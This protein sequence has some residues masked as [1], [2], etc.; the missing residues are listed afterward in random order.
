MTKVSVVVPVYNASKYLR[1]TLDSL[2]NQSLE[3]MEIIA[4]DDVS[5]DNSLDILKEYEKAYPNKIRVLVNSKNLGQGAT[6][7]KGIKLAKGKYI[8]FVDSDDYVSFDM[9]K[10]M[11]ENASLN[12]FPEVVTM[13]LIFVKDNYYFD[14]KFKDLP[15]RKG[16]IVSLEEDPSFILNQSPSTCNKLF[17]SDTIKSALFLENVMWEDVA[18]TYAKMFN[19]KHILNINTPGYFY[20]RTLNG[21]SG[22]GYNI[23]PNILDIIKVADQLEKEVKASK[24]YDQFKHQIEYIQITSC[25]QRVVEIMSWPIPTT[26]I[27]Q[28]CMLMCQI[29]ISKYGDWKR[30]SIEELS[31]KVGYLELERINNL[32]E[33]A[34]IS[35]ISDVS[36]LEE[37]VNSFLI[38]R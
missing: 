21:V 15:K 9:Y 27:N 10:T 24:R 17:R 1:T 22:K 4:I 37:Q 34:V 28:L 16:T 36:Y 38:N 13:G 7:N 26:E 5:T 6:R 31:I 20:R 30:F 3:D 12:D 19:A 8:G 33:N 11:Y 35:N 29:I 23:N 14:N 18:F 32:I 25:L 2:I